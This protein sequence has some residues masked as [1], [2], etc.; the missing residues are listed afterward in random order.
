MGKNLIL[1]IVVAIFGIPALIYICVKGGF[2]LLGFTI[3]L[4]VVG[5]AE[6]SMML[7]AKGYRSSLFLSVLLPLVFVV[8]AFYGYEVLDLLTITIFIHTIIIVI[9]YSR[10][11]DLK[12][13]EFPADFLGRLLPVFYVGLLS[14]YIIRLSKD[15]TIGGYLLILVFMVVW[16]SDTAAYFGGKL[17][18]KHKL[19]ETVSPKK[20]WEGFY[21]GFLGALIAA[22]VAKLVFLN[23]D[24]IKVIVLALAACLFGQIGDLFESAIKRHCGVKDSSAILPGHGGILD[25]FDSFL[26]AVPIVYLILLVW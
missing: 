12:L 20:T 21:F 11:K 10:A 3:L 26:F 4:A 15:F 16:A 9:D 2:F 23:L 14:S 25:R 5:G 19:S 13:T 1:R 6:I 22:V 18:G 8:C 24:W 7:S 17:M